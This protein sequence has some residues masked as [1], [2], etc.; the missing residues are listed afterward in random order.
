MGYSIVKKRILDILLLRWSVSQVGGANY[1]HTFQSTLTN[2]EPL[3]TLSVCLF[4]QR[5][6]ITAYLT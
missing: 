5:L 2:V 4:T 6:W 3:T 1:V